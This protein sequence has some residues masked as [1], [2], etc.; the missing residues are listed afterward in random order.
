M[1]GSGLHQVL[2]AEL[3]ERDLDCHAEGGIHHRAG[4]M[5]TLGTF[6]SFY[7]NAIDLTMLLMYSFNILTIV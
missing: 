5:T 7:N 2:V 3:I 4:N 6:Q 1:P